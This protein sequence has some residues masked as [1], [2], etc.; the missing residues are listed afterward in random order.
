MK[1]CFSF[2][3]FLFFYSLLPLG[4]RG[5][6]KVKPIVKNL[7]PSLAPYQYDSYAVKEVSYGTKEK[8]DLLEFSVYSNEEYKLVF[9]KTVLPQEIGITIYE[10][11]PKKKGQIIFIDESGMKDKYTCNFK[12]TKTGTYYIQFEIPVAT[13]PNQKGCFVVLIGIKEE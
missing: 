1:Q 10:G 9:G 12:P 7:M 5:Q 13:A 3:I 6:C 2:I 4:V 8:K 11:N